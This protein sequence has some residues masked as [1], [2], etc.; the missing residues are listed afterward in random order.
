M[1]KIA[2][3]YKRRVGKDTSCDYLIQKYGGIKL[4]FAEPLYKILN[5]AQEVCHFEKVKDRKFLQFIGTEWARS[6]QNDVWVNL[7]IKK[8]KSHTDQNIFIS[9]VRFQN[10]FKILKENNFIMVQIKNKNYDFIDGYANHQSDN[11]LECCCEWDYTIEN[12]GSLD[13]L[14]LQLDKLIKIEILNQK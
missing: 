2:F 1:V 10:E 7:L 4:S 12:Y 9:D 14:Y 6:I 3:G 8:I 13:N 11:D 5:F